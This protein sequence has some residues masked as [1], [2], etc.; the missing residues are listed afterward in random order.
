[1]YSLNEYIFNELNI[2]SLYEAGGSQPKKPKED[3]RTQEQKDVD[4]ECQRLKTEKDTKI[5]EA[6]D[7]NDLKNQLKTYYDAAIKKADAKKKLV[8][9]QAKKAEI[10]KKKQEEIQK[11]NGDATK[12]NKINQKYSKLMASAEKSISN[13]Q[14]AFDKTPEPPA[15]P[16][17]VNG[18]GDPPAGGN[19]PA[20]TEDK[21]DDKIKK[22]LKDKYSAEGAEVP[23]EFKGEDGKFDPAKVDAL[24]G[25]ALKDA[26]K[27]GGIE[28]QKPKPASPEEK[29]LND[30]KINKDG[31]TKEDINKFK[32]KAENNKSCGEVFANLSPLS[33]MVLAIFCP[34]SIS[35]I[36]GAMLP[37]AAMKT[38]LDGLSDAKDDE[39]NEE[40][41]KISG[42]FADDVTKGVQNSNIE[43][44]ETALQGCKDVKNSAIGKDGTLNTTEQT[45]KNLATTT[46]G[47]AINKT[48]ELVRKVENG[49]IEVDEARAQSKLESLKA[50]KA[51]K[52]QEAGDDEKKKQDIENE[53]KEKIE[54][55]EEEV[56]AAHN[57]EKLEKAEVKDPD[58]K[59]KTINVVMHTGPNGGRFYYPKGSPHDSE[60]KVY[61]K[62]SGDVTTIPL[63]NYIIEKLKK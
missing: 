29:L 47:E 37:G 35:S 42:E 26:A 32:E 2:E 6:G 13:T 58:D 59:S 4:A 3:K 41:D 46:T 53:Y 43:D 23:A 7:N 62:E 49:E 60:H 14:T 50:D 38:G 31:K 33:I 34:D 44:K 10:E 56:E 61:V 48:T 1:M 25:D 9:S 39:E 19:P 36:A 18:G 40:I 17:G 15:A 45:A 24:S 27:K 8:D 30:P 5:R 51:R 21:T 20:S 12:L 55:K 28:T 16:A 63:Y 22:E 54:S 52:L 57:H 11:A